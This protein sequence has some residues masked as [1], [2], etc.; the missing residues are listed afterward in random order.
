MRRFY[1]QVSWPSILLHERSDTKEDIE[2]ENEDL[3]RRAEKLVLGKRYESVQ[4]AFE[5][6][7]PS[8]WQ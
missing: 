4:K 5:E 8:L 1:A 6:P 2:E 7:P 3:R